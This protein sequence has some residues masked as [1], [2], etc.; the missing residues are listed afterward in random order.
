M[1][2]ALTDTNLH[3]TLPR[4]VISELTV[5][6]VTILPCQTQTVLDDRSKLMDYPCDQVV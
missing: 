4:N 6:A 1:N 5:W 3:V 2:L